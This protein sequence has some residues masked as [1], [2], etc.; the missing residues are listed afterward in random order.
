[1]LCR[2]GRLTLSLIKVTL[3]SPLCDLPENRPPGPPY[4]ACRRVRQR[5]LYVQLNADAKCRVGSG[6]PG[7]T[8]CLRYS[9]HVVC[10]RARAIGRTAACHVGCRAAAGRRVLPAHQRRQ[11]LRARRALP[12]S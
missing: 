6:Q 5:R 8:Y 11:L 2:K 12:Q 9:L 4:L 7:V 3:I 1:V 10:T